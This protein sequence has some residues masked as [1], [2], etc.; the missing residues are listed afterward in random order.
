MIILALLLVWLGVYLNTPDVYYVGI[1]F[2]YI[3]WLL[4]KVSWRGRK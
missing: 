4:F 3:W 1:V 2:W